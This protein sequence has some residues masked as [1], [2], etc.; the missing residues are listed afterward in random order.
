MK[1]ICVELPYDT[2][3]TATRAYLRDDSDIFPA[4]AADDEGI[5]RKSDMSQS[6]SAAVFATRQ[7]PEAPGRFILSARCVTF[8]MAQRISDGS[9]CDCRAFETSVM[10]RE[11]K[12]LRRRRIPRPVGKGTRQSG[13]GC[14]V[15]ANGLPRRY[16]P[17]E[18]GEACQHTAVPPWRE[19]ERPSRRSGDG[20]DMSHRPRNITNS[21][22]AKRGRSAPTHISEASLVR[23]ATQNTVSRRGGF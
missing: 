23:A 18:A 21:S 5:K 2:N 15:W 7:L 4:C 11:R 9:V 12:R 8:H 20:S 3:N 6:D 1:E 13:G 16:A 10:R 19:R 17:A 22:G 14:G